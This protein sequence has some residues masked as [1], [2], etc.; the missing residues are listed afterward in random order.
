LFFPVVRIDDAFAD[1]LLEEQG[2]ILAA[3]QGT[4]VSSVVEERAGVGFVVGFLFGHVGSM[5][6]V[7]KSAREGRALSVEVARYWSVVL[8]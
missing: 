2:R 4:A 6:R 1:T 8:R 5:A 3:D 7:G